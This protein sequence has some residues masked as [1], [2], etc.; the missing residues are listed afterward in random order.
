MAR[1]RGKQVEVY[2]KLNTTLKYGF[3]T[4]K[5]V[6]DAYKSALGQTTYAGATGVFFGANSPKPF[7]ASKTFESGTIG[8]FCS[9]DKLDTLRSDGWTI[10]KGRRIRGIKTGG[11][12]RTV[13]TIMPGDWKYAWNITAGEVGLGQTLGFTQATAAD[14]AELIWG[15]NYPKPPR[16]SKAGTDGSVSTFVEPKESTV[17][18]AVN[19]GY[20]ISSVDY[21]LRT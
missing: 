5:D 8:S 9:Y 3:K 20:S 19:G 4:T 17:E 14:A 18:A 10:G 16:A 7:R 12:T 1:R 2:V 21:A 15:V 6:H 11:R 13:Y